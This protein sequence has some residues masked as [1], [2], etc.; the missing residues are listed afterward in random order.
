VLQHL[1]A[2]PG[3]EA[4]LRSSM[5]RLLQ[6]RTALVIA[7]RLSTVYQANQILVLEGGR[8]VETGTHSELISQQGVYA[9]LVNK[10]GLEPNNLTLADTTQIN[11]KSESA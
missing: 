10:I 4:E 3:L 6:G 1:D 9:R 11:S 7:H 2:D 5:Q 8:I